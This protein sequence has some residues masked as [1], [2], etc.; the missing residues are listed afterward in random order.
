[1]ITFEK[2]RHVWSKYSV[3]EDE[4]LSL[5]TAISVQ[6]S[7]GKKPSSELHVLC[8]ALINRDINTVS[9]AKSF[10]NPLNNSEHDPFAMKGMQSAVER[11]QRAIDDNEVIMVY[12][13][14]DVDGTTSVAMMMSYLQTKTKKV[15]Y[16]IPDRHKEGYGISSEGVA[17]AADQGAT[18]CI[19]LDCGITAVDEISTGRDKGIDF[20]VCDHHT[21]A[22]TVPE[23]IILNPKQPE[24][25]YPY[26]E[27]S[28]CAIG[29]KFISAYETLHP[30]TFD[31]KTLL[32]F[33]A[34]SLACD[35]VPLKDENR[36]LAAKGIQILRQNRRPS[37]ELMLGIDLTN[38]EPTV[39][40]LVF[41]IGPKVN[42]AGRMDHGHR[43]V[44]LM[45]EQNLEKARELFSP[46]LELNVERRSHEQIATL[47]AL[48]DLEKTKGQRFTNVVYR[49]EW[50][51][52]VI[53][54]VAS[55]LIEHYY[56][57][58]VVFTESNGNLVGSARSIQNFDLY[59]VLHSCSHHFIQF[60]G[61]KYAAGIELEASKLQQFMDEFEQQVKKR[62]RGIP[63]VSTLYYEMDLEC[64]QVTLSLAKKLQRLSPFGPGNHR[65]AFVVRNL[66]DSGKSRAVGKEN[67]HLQLFVTSNT[68]SGRGIKGIAF[69]MG[70]LI[71][72]IQQSEFDILTHISINRW[73]GHEE[74]QLEVKD[75][76]FH[77]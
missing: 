37:F 65:P 29:Y 11:L 57:P 20:I 23:A 32:D 66:R 12:G 54:I 62:F 73:K 76:R 74:V 5:A 25:T 9:A 55:R 28:G 45:L 59:E 53:G 69:G 68:N 58:T 4:V 67:D 72:R 15:F 30:G 64:D 31:I 49:P 41:K 71:D 51:K 42:S 35:I 21:P 48:E 52:G 10:L 47:E 36:H 40:D 33:V 8:N 39:A 60:G 6:K 44:D 77:Q 2:M 56:R 19:A 70:G 16:Y 34:V 63:P 26:K 38:E 3:D 27:L 43:A 14:Y 18:L 75:I 24:C 13:D 22:A 46:L 17:F 7:P 1:M 50:H 61:H